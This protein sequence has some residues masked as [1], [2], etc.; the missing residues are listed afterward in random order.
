M[1]EWTAEV[2]EITEVVQAGSGSAVA[3]FKEPVYWPSR[4]SK[5]SKGGF[6]V[7]VVCEGGSDYVYLQFINDKDNKGNMYIDLGKTFKI[8]PGY[9]LQARSG[10]PLCNGCSMVVMGKVWFDEDGDYTVIL[11]AGVG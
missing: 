9:L 11:R 7:Q 10:A 4:L 2:K 8:P 6:T 5:G 1:V 3:K